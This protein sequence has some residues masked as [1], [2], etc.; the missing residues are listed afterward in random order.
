MGPA[1]FLLRHLET[2]YVL[3]FAPGTEAMDRYATGPIPV[4]LQLLQSMNPKFIAADSLINPS[5][6]L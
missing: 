3:L 2:V 4:H 5:R 6:M 1:T